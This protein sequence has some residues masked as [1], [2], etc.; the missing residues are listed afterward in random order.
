MRNDETKVYRIPENYIG[1]GRVFNGLFKTRNFVEAVI[2]F[3]IVAVPAHALVSKAGISVRIATPLCAGLFVAIFVYN[4]I[5]G[6]P[7]S[8]GILTI[9]KFYSSR[10]IYVYEKTDSALKKA[11]S[12]SMSMDTSPINKFFSKLNNNKRETITYEDLIEGENYEKD[13]SYLNSLRFKTQKKNSAEIMSV[14][15]TD[16]SMDFTFEYGKE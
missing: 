2:I 6:E 1:E 5:N 10:T 7:F 16:A 4:G 12:S 9:I 13:G 14:Y 8:K 3:I 11:P 15:T